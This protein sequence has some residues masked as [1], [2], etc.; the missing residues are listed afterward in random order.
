M[1]TAELDM[2]ISQTSDMVWFIWRPCQHDDGYMTVTAMNG[3]RFKVSYNIAMC[4]SGLAS[5]I[6]DII[7]PLTR[8]AII[9][10]SLIL[11]SSKTYI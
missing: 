9:L 10:A 1:V 2:H 5:A 6:F 4:I 7:I 8:Y 11:E 3:H